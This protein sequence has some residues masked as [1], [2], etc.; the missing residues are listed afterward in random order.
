MPQLNNTEIAYKYRSDKELKLAHFLFKFM[1]S[2]MLTKVGI[3]GTRFAISTHMPISKISKEN[4][5]Q[6]ILRR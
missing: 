6:T 1:N 2:P 5:F 3:A 4:Y